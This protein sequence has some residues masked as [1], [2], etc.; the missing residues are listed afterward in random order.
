MGSTATPSQIPSSRRSIR[1]GTGFP[2]LGSNFNGYA[3]SS[4]TGNS[5][6]VIKRVFDKNRQEFIPPKFGRRPD[7]REREPR[8]PKKKELPRIITDDRESRVPFPQPA[9]DEEG[10]ILVMGSS[11]AGKTSFINVASGSRLP[12]SSGLK[13]CTS[14]VELSEPFMLNGRKLRLI[15]TPGFDDSNRSDADV[16]GTIA[17]FLAKEF[18]NGRKLQGILYFHRISDVR[19]GALSKRNFTMFQKLCGEHSYPNVVLVTSRW[20]EVNEQVGIGRENELRSK[21][22]FF[23]PLLEA[24]ASLL[25]YGRNV[26][27][28]HSILQQVLDKPPV[29]LR[30]QQETVLEGKKIVE[31]EAGMALHTEKLASIQQFEENLK[32]LTQ[33]IEA[34]KQENDTEAQKELEADMNDLKNKVVQLQGENQRLLNRQSRVEVVEYEVV[35]DKR[36]VR[37][38]SVFSWVEVDYP[39]SPL[40]NGRSST[41]SGVPEVSVV[42]PRF[43]E[44]PEVSSDGTHDTNLSPRIIG[45]LPRWEEKQMEEQALKSDSSAE[46]EE[47][48]LPPQKPMHGG[49]IGCDEGDSS[50][51]WREWV[52]GFPPSLYMTVCYLLGG[53]VGPTTIH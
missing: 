52:F 15:D 14:N 24:G 43:L 10:Y 11:G 44:I 31:T 37:K 32:G 47:T 48:C 9:N 28:A 50:L 25:R 22:I 45:A 21:A 18:I 5:G 27:S 26:E 19:M 7:P 49:G 3:S 17:D 46:V 20:S 12:V 6:F 34:V 1:R 4:L 8:E 38:L 36:S 23:R 51:T 16:L 53:Y 39:K 35:A 2:T 41:A 40:D 13:S 33:E 29:T 42:F 30:I